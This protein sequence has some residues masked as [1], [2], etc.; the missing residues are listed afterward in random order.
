MIEENSL[1]KNR[2]YIILSF[3]TNIGVKIAN[4]HICKYSAERC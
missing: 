2:K 3:Y 4:K 1:Q